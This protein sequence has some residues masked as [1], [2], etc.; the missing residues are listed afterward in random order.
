[1]LNFFKCNCCSSLIIWTFGACDSDLQ[2]EAHIQRL[3][4]PTIMCIRTVPTNMCYICMVMWSITLAASYILKYLHTGKDV[5]I[6]MSNFLPLAD[7]VTAQHIGRRRVG[8]TFIYTLYLRKYTSADPFH[9]I[10][11]YFILCHSFWAQQYR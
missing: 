2:T 6:R 9:K 3:L 1:M 5:K 10:V 8:I 11:F 4:N 7:C